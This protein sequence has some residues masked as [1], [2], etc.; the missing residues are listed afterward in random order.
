M[1]LA[2]PDGSAALTLSAAG[3]GAVAL[4]NL[5]LTPDGGD[6]IGHPFFPALLHDLLRALRQDAAD[7]NLTPGLA[8]DV[9]VPTAG[10]SAV[11]MVDPENKPISAEVVASGRNT[12]LA[13]PAAKAP[14]IYR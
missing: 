12:R 13:L 14:G 7:P 11:T 8:L 10:E 3:R 5:P 2:Y 1:V 4:A 6:F 9:D